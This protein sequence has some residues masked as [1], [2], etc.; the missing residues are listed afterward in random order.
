VLTALLVGVGVAVALEGAAYALAPEAMKRF[1][2]Q[3]MDMPGDQLRIAGL[4]ALVS[5]V[6]LVA[7]LLP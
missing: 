3:I 7:I 1:L 2:I 5:G 6:A 4:V